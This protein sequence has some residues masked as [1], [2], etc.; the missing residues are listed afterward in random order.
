MLISYKSTLWS[1]IEA[2]CRNINKSFTMEITIDFTKDNH[3]NSIKELKS[4]KKKDLKILIK[5][6]QLRDNIFS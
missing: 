3:Q 1:L 2:D 6:K 4:S 5:N